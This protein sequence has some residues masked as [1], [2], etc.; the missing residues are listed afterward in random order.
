MLGLSVFLGEGLKAE[1]KSYLETLQQAGFS[2]VFTSLHIPEEDATLYRERL[3]TLG[4]W[5]QALQMDLTADI[6]GKALEKIGLTIA[7]PVSIK[8]TGIT[9]LRVDD[10]FSNREIADLSHHLKVALNA[11]TIDEEDVQELIDDGADFKQLTAFHN[12][13]PRPETGLDKKVLI[14]KNHWLKSIGFRVAAFVPG[15][16]TFRGPLY[17]HLPTL[18]EHRERHPL[19]SAIELQKDCLTDDVYIGDPMIKAFT[20]RQFQS[21]HKNKTYLLRVRPVADS[22][23]FDFILGQHQNRR[24]PARDVIRS[25]GARLNIHGTVEPQHTFIRTKGSV[26]I[27]N[28][29][30]GRY[31]GETQIVVSDLPADEKVNVAAQVIQE[32][33]DLLQLIK[34]GDLFELQNDI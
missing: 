19:A 28:C 3:E 18:E 16:K 33:R 29:L 9:S 26:T 11:S 4:Y 7:D 31:M 34:A 24:D 5:T 23:W 21:Y 8:Q 13:Y 10:G 27:D 15:D 1:T 30:Y 6:S 12:Y 2:S 14:Q 20:I 17:Q 25:A 22:Q 32:D